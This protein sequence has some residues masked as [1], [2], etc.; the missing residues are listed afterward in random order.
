MPATALIPL[1]VSAGIGLY[2]A[3]KNSSASKYQRQSD[4][5]ALA[6]EKEQDRLNR[7]DK[8][9]DREL[10]RRQ[11]DAIEAQRAQ[12]SALFAGLLRSRGI[13]VPGYTA[14]PYGGEAHAGDTGM[15]R[16]PTSLASF[17]STPYGDTGDP[18]GVS[19]P[20]LTA[21]SAEGTIDDFFRRRNYNV[22]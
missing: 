14:M 13:N 1:A 16:S 5:E 8:N 7:A 22:A 18:T 15:S 19:T 12:R 20:R 11:F 21:P 17:Y 6:W 10:Q 2:K 9:T 4:E 3:G